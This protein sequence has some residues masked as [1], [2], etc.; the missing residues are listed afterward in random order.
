M[1][2]SITNILGLLTITSVLLSGTSVPAAN[3][4]AKS[5]AQVEST[6]LPRLAGDKGSL[7]L[8]SL[9]AYN[10][11]WDN[12]SRDSHGPMPLGNGDIGTNAWVEEGGDLV[13]YVSKTDA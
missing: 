10:V 8:T 11:A 1:R 7:P 2:N 12:P 4:G 3:E 9:G 5:K 13:F 6:T